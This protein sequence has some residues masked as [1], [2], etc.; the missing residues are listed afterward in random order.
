MDS[1]SKNC[2]K[3]DH[4]CHCSAPGDEHK[5]IVSCDCDNC[6]CETVQE[7]AEQD[8]YEHSIFLGRV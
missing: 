3:C 1:M 2:K 6:E 5:V 4:I 8:T 7:K